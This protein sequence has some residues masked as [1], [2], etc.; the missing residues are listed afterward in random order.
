MSK[1]PDSRRMRSA[2]LAFTLLV[3]LTLVSGG[4]AGW[5]DNRWGLPPDLLAAGKNLDR[6]PRRVGDWALES[7]KSLAAVAEELLQCSGSTQRV[8]RNQKTGEAVT[9]ALIVGP[10]G[11]I[12]VHTPEVCYSSRDYK[13]ISGPKPFRVGSSGS[14]DAMFWGMSLEATDLQ[15][16]KLSVAYAWNDEH[17][18]A[19]P[20]HPRFEFAGAK[21]LYKL[22]LAAPISDR[23]ESSRVDPCH[24]FLREFL[25]ALDASLFEAE[26][27]D[28]T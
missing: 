3:A 15:G 14:D 28:K 9:V 4:V 27:A 11:P 22:Q 23:D 8:Y 6:V 10:S 12:S 24:A 18:W 21:L 2:A 7:A 17:G 16:G 19:A 20:K 26:P 13:T 1:F 25:P 5:L